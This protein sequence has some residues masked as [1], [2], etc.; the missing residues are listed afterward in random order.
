MEIN[1]TEFNTCTHLMKFYRSG[2]SKSLI[3]NASFLLQHDDLQ[4]QPKKCLT[5]LKMNSSDM[6]M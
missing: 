2:L 6:M 5:F 3:T 4:H 1:K